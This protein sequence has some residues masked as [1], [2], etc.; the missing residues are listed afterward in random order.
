MLPHLIAV[1]TLSTSL[2]VYNGR[3]WKNVV[4]LSLVPSRWLLLA[5]CT[6]LWSSQSTTLWHLVYTPKQ[7]LN[8]VGQVP[9]LDLYWSNGN[10]GS[11][12][13]PRITQL[14]VVHGEFKHSSSNS[15][16]CDPKVIALHWKVRCGVYLF[17]VTWSHETLGMSSLVH[18]RSKSES[19]GST[20]FV[21]TPFTLVFVPSSSPQKKVKLNW[22]GG[23][24]FGHTLIVK[25]CL[26]YL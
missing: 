16:S 4:T 25:M 19:C 9:L 24:L 7:P 20:Y 2:L 13:M 10:S 14:V 21:W 18:L 5:S 23:N 8:K 1:I 3:R 15:R 22:E 6:L 11:N 26:N 17:T 12:D